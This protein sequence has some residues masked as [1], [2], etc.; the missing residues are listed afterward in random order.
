MGV[1]YDCLAVFDKTRVNRKEETN[2]RR[3]R[4]GINSWVIARGGSRL[5]YKTSKLNIQTK[6]NRQTTKM[7]L[8]TNEMSPFENWMSM[9]EIL[10]PTL[11]FDISF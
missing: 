3:Q 4:V 1:F 11:T 2:D 7:K 9:V 6:Y 5:P 10:S 8:K